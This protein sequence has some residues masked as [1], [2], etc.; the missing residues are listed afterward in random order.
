METEE[1]WYTTLGVAPG[2]SPEELK[3][4]YRTL[5]KVWHPDRF[6]SDAALQQQALD[7]FH[8]LTRAYNA[9]C[10]AVSAQEVTGS[11]PERRQCGPRVVWWWRGAVGLGLSGLIALGLCLWPPH[12]PPVTSPSITPSFTGLPPEVLPPRHTITVGSTKHEV[13]TIQGPPTVETERL[14]EYRG[15]R[16]Y[17]REG[18]VTGWDIWPG[19]PLQVRLSPTLPVIPVPEYFAVGSTK[20]EVLVVQGT[21]T[22]LTEHLW[23]YGASRVLFTDNRVIKW[24]EW[25]GAPLKVRPAG[26]SPVP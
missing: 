11:L 13:R 18:H 21:P 12:T 14:W 15:S 9:L 5:I 6:A 25:P 8:H 17:F 2:V 24:D 26:D 3:R 16:V 1:T 7:H 20:D 23:E 19:A 10:I 4:A 22:R